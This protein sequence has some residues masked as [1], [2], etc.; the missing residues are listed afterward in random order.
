MWIL[1]P[2]ASGC[3]VGCS[4][5]HVSSSWLRLVCGGLGSNG[6]RWQEVCGVGVCG[7]LEGGLS[8]S[9]RGEGC[10]DLRY[11]MDS[12]QKNG[13]SGGSRVSLDVVVRV[14]YLRLL[15]CNEHCCTRLIS[16]KEWSRCTNGCLSVLI[17]NRILMGLNKST[18]IDRWHCDA[19]QALKVAYW[20]CLQCHALLEV[21]I[22]DLLDE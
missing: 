13:R 12:E 15:N 2:E 8:V 14:R 17:Q 10:R 4:C 16:W 21:I 20:R 3:S 19:S 18:L 11:A 1:T 9:H 7:M 5:I 22:I 6:I